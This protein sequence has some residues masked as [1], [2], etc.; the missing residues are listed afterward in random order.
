M[1]ERAPPLPPYRM[2]KWPDGTKVREEEP[3]E[4]P[5]RPNPEGQAG[6][7]RK[8]KAH[9]PSR[10]SQGPGAG[11][12]APNGTPL[13]A[14]ETG[15]TAMAPKQGPGRAQLKGVGWRRSAPEFW[16]GLGPERPIS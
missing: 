6:K 1:L 12:G 2:A 14:P 10:R 9:L 4:I 7:S 13:H 15:G 16:S 11:K 3:T 5:K 8:G